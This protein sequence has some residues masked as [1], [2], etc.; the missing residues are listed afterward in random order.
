[1]TKE[2]IRNEI[3]N[4]LIVDAAGGAKAQG[5]RVTDDTNNCNTQD[6]QGKVFHIDLQLSEKCNV[7]TLCSAVFGLVEKLNGSSLQV[8]GL[9]AELEHSQQ[10]IRMEFSENQDTSSFEDIFEMM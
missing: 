2:E 8:T 10:S 9:R 6:R 5:R 1:M 3:G 7:L 4:M